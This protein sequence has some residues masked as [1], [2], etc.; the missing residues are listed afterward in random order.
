MKKLLERLQL[1]SEFL[2]FI[3]FFTF[4]DS[5][6]SR[7][8]PGQVINLYTFTPESVI[9]AIPNFL[10]IVLLLRYSYLKIHGN[11]F[12]LQRKKALLSFLLGLI[13]WILIS[14]AFSLFIALAFGNFE[15]N[16]MGEVVFLSNFTRVLDFMI[17]GGF[18]FAFLLFR[19]FQ[20]HQKKLADYD[21][22]MS[23][24]TIY[25]LK[26][27]L[28]PHF[29]F[30]NLN[31]LDQLIEENPAVASEFLHEFSEIYRY[32]LEKSDSHLVPLK[33]E[34][35]F[36]LNYFRLL[37]RKFGA[38]YKLEVPNEIPDFWI[39]PLTLQVLIENAVFHNQGSESQP[40]SI[41]IQVNEKIAVW[42]QLK[43]YKHKKHSGGRGLKN[44]IKQYRLLSK[45][46]LEIVK[47]ND[48]FTV[49]LPLIKEK[50]I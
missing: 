37:S 3:I 4:L 26:Q 10:I 40:I 17:Y 43:P 1:S 20:E 16:F 12:P 28:N 21:Q 42:N 15:R 5:I 46:T 45:E 33:E 27:Q 6:K 9:T 29:L 24:L 38:G 30:N 14:N 23:E 49:E 8:G 44:L 13:G 50:V 11:Q 36:S 19:K 47:T 48:S 31:V 2:L 35:A 22:A 34:L 7:I 41:S 39:P 18:Y 25:Q 32:A